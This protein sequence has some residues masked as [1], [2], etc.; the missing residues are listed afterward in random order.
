ME[1]TMA[2]LFLTPDPRLLLRSDGVLVHRDVE[3]EP[4]EPEDG[5]LSIALPAAFGRALDYLTVAPTVRP[6][7]P[8]FAT[9]DSVQL[10]A[11]IRKVFETVPTAHDWFQFAF[12]ISDLAGWSAP[13]DP[14]LDQVQAIDRLLHDYFK[15]V[16][17][18]I[19]A[20]W[21]ATRLAMLADVQ[22]HAAAAREVIR[23]IFQNH[24]DLTAPLTVARL[25][26]A[27]HDS[28][29][30][31]NAFTGGLDTGYWLRPY[32]ES[33]IS[34][35]GWAH[36]FVDRAPVFSDG[37]VWDP[38]LALPTLLYALAVR[39]MVLVALHGG[40][41]RRYC[42]EI[43][44]IVQF[45]LSV[46]FRWQD[47]I[48]RKGAL[49]PEELAFGAGFTVLPFAAGAIDVYTGNDHLIDV[50]V[51]ALNLLYALGLYVQP[52][53]LG[54]P[55]LDPAQVAPD[56]TRDDIDLRS[57]N[58]CQPILQKQAA[59]S[60]TRLRWNTGLQDFS[61]TIKALGQICAGTQTSR[62]IQ[63]YRDSMKR[64]RS[65]AVSLP[66]AADQQAQW[67]AELAR[68]L[69]QLLNEPKDRASGRAMAQK[70][71]LYCAL[72]DDQ[73]PL[74]SDLTQLLRKHLNDGTRG[75]QSEAQ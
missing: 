48:R 52:L 47:G 3:H 26:Q 38:R 13:S 5:D 68:C 74:I 17:Q 58:N 25:A 16:D 59:L 63:V 57:N 42:H 8:Y 18:E 23:S 31:V 7:H 55:Y 66:G 61:D 46:Q 34:L 1:A 75:L 30:A 65:G 28:S 69:S 50:D 9:R 60:F 40:D 21:S 67:R 39:V 32:S 56:I 41:S 11:N 64:V 14:L 45:L 71:E 12:A 54:V 24:D 51:D 15:R 27:E 70:F 36:K 73:G 53:P 49:T 2:D 35:E 20:S 22:S 44:Q 33:A 19:F 43:N 29:V 62:I 10:Y 4:S 37:T 6:D 72:Q